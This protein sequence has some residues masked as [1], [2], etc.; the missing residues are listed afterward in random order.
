MWN[1]TC[2]Q[3]SLIHITSRFSSE[4]ELWG[5]TCLRVCARV[6]LPS[7]T[8]GNLSSWQWRMSLIDSRIE[9]QKV[10]LCCHSGLMTWGPL[11]CQSSQRQH[12][13]HDPVKCFCSRQPQWAGLELRHIFS[14][15]WERLLSLYYNHTWA[16]WTSLTHPQPGT[17]WE[18]T[19]IL[20]FT[21]RRHVLPIFPEALRSS[22][23][24]CAF[25]FFLKWYAPL[26]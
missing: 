3:S 8:Q 6:F 25:C 5:I 9:K 13:G 17:Q 1:Y 18:D 14:F 24:P 4:A 20:T 12:W 15:H 2:E 7:V 11:T 10:S 22:S 19:V 21:Q 16:I 26:G 23:P